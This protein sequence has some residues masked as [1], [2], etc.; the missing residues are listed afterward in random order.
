MLFAENFFCTCHFTVTDFFYL[1]P[2]NWLKEEKWKG[3]DK[4]E[5]IDMNLIKMLDWSTSIGGH[6]ILCNKMKQ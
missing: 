6:K 3:N 1:S 4:K 5:K 2:K